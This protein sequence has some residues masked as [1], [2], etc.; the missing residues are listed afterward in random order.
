MTKNQSGGFL[1]H[2]GKMERGDG[3]RLPPIWTKRLGQ[4]LPQQM[5]SVTSRLVQERI[6]LYRILIFMW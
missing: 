1:E 6:S 4:I 5:K 2:S 3:G